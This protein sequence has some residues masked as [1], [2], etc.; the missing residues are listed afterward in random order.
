MLCFVGSWEKVKVLIFYLLFV[1]SKTTPCFLPSLLS[2]LLFNSVESVK[3]E[4]EKRNEK[5]R[6]KISN[7]LYIFKVVSTQL[8]ECM[9]SWNRAHASN[10]YASTTLSVL[11]V[12]RLYASQ[13]EFPFHTPFLSNAI[14]CAVVLQNFFAALP[15]SLC[16]SISLTEEV[17]CW[18]GKSVQLLTVFVSTTPFSCLLLLLLL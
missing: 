1:P 10:L 3:L 4:M 17:S 7:F 8:L 5:G 15:F 12:A 11:G 14:T 16:L 9:C 2:A 13:A 18:W 6:A